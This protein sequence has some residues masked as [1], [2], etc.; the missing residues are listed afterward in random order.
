M[1]S[2]VG[3]LFSVPSTR[4]IS[5][6]QPR[7]RSR[8]SRN[9][10]PTDTICES[11]PSPVPNPD[12]LPGKGADENSSGPRL[13]RVAG[14]K[15]ARRRATKSI[16]DSAATGMAMVRLGLRISALEDMIKRLDQKLG[17]ELL[18]EQPNMNGP[19]QPLRQYVEA[20]K[21]EQERTMS[22]IADAVSKAVGEMS[23]VAEAG[24]RLNES[25]V[26]AGQRLN[27][28]V[29]KQIRDAM[30]FIIKER[31]EAQQ[32]LPEMDWP[33]RLARHAE[34][35]RQTQGELAGETAPPPSPPPALLP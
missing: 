7:A 16:S 35:E 27:E 13:F 25:V 5:H 12:R 14:K 22:T 31:K 23:G 21:T 28:S 9:A 29:E 30:D 11:D 3:E 34:V 15:P 17:R 6:C 32:E 20:F 26:E 1:S 8:N 4:R 2:S 10:S 24:R 18:S 19:P 33:D